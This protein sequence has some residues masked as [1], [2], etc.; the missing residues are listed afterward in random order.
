MGTIYRQRVN[1]VSIVGRLSTL[2]SVH[3]QRFHCITMAV[4]IVAISPPHLWFLVRASKCAGCESIM[5]LVALAF[6]MAC[7]LL[8][9]LS[10]C[11]PDFYFPLWQKAC[12]S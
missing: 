1:S 12:P 7:C 2:G 6:L 3:H 4:C 11:S 9:P 8:Q 10:L 5:S